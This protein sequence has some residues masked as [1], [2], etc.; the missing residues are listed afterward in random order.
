[1]LSVLIAYNY[2]DYQNQRLKSN[3]TRALGVL[4]LLPSNFHIVSLAF[5]KA[6][7]PQQLLE[8]PRVMHMPLL[9]RNSAWE[10]GNSRNLP[11]IKE[12]IDVCSGG[13]YDI[14]GYINSD[15][16]LGKEFV[17]CLDGKHDA[18]VMARSE[19]AEVAPEEFASGFKKVIYGGDKHPGADG[20]FFSGSWWNKNRNLF[21]EDL[22]LGETEWDT[23]YRHIIRTK[24]K[25]FVEK[26]CIYHVYHDSQWNNESIGAKNN[27]QIWNEVKE[28][29]K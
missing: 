23:A 3:Q 13:R 6:K 19:I 11:Y 1:M 26:R 20:F 18:Y 24:S 28:S 5:E 22:I 8:F 4:S 17:S 25:N 15:I 9:K 10:I 7:K 2:V 29:V 21:P 27:I 16:L 14:I 12:I